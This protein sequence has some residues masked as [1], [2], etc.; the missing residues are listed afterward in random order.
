MGVDEC[1]QLPD[2][3]VDAAVRANAAYDFLV[4]CTGAEAA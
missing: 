1:G 3:A 4:L 2:V